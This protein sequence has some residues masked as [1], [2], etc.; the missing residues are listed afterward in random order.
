MFTNARTGFPSADLFY[1]H[2]SALK[3]YQMID[4]VYFHYITSIFP[5]NEGK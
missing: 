5:E 4:A 3:A 1:K 2:T